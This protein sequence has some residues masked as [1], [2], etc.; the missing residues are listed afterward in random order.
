MRALGVFRAVLDWFSFRERKPCRRE[1]SCSM[2]SRDFRLEIL[3]KHSY[4]QNVFSPIKIEKEYDK[5]SVVLT[6][7]V[8]S[9]IT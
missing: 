8:S 6:A 9:T 1:I 5:C 2:G 3:N 7:T 4:F